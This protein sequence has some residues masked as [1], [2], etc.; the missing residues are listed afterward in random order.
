MELH[1]QHMSASSYQERTKPMTTALLVRYQNTI[2]RIQEDRGAAMAE[3]GLL[4][5]MVALAAIGILVFFGGE[6][7]EVFTEAEASVDGRGAVPAA[8]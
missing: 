1:T 4:L 6:I 5:A 2:A 3:Y 7:V 8:D